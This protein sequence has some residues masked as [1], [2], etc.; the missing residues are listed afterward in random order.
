MQERS[1]KRVL[2]SGLHNVLFRIH[3]FKFRAVTKGHKG[4]AH[5]RFGKA[6]HTYFPLNFF[7]LGKRGKKHDAKR[8][9]GVSASRTHP[10]VFPTRRHT[11]T[12]YLP[13]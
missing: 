10:S 4:R 11:G 12:G 7:T 2:L 8:T 6:L 13:K 5:A 9:M 1:A 3:Y